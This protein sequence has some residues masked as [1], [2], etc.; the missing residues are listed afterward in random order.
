MKWTKLLYSALMA[1][2]I[3][4]AAQA[5]LGL[6]AYAVAGGLLASGAIVPLVS[7]YYTESNVLR[8]DI[9]VEIW[10]N[11]IEG[12]I[13]KDNGFLRKSKNADKYITGT[14]VVHI[15]Q[16]GGSGN[17]VKNRAFG[18]APVRQRIDNDIVYLIDEWTTDPVTIRHRDEVELSYDKRNDVLGEDRDALVQAVAEECLWYWTNSPVYKNYGA[19][20]LPATHKFTTSGD[21]QPAT[22][23]GATGL[24]KKATRGDLQKLQIYF[25]S[26][27]RWFDGKMNILLPPSMLLD[28]YPADSIITVTL[29][30]SV[31][32]EER[33]MG[34]L[35]KDQGFN[36]YS[37][38][39]VMKTDDDGVILAPGEATEA[40][41]CEAAIAWYEQAVEFAFGKVEAFESLKNPQWYG[42]ITSFLVRSGGRAVREDYKGIA[43]L[44]QA[45]T[46]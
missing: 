12:E 4:T 7:Q 10:Q 14:R 6:N 36:I 43:L 40:D 21:A 22:I 29:M 28:M 25:R 38:S 45:T 31:T 13:F 33:R 41:S 27:D 5:Y 20:T 19:T 42:D 3:G 44:Y 35:M 46:V 23:G 8:G 2:M 39:S 17:V 26:I 32:E 18:A 37:R 11:H 34:I 1:M 16:S 15:P 30:A 9:I 24:R